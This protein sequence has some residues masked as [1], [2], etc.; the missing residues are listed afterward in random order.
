MTA[1]SNVSYAWQARRPL[2]RMVDVIALTIV[3]GIAAGFAHSAELA[4]AR[5]IQG[6][7]VWFSRDF[8]WMSPIA[9]TLVLLPG[10]VLLALLALASGSRWILGL[11]VLSTASAAVFGALLPYSQ[12]ARVVSL[13]LALVVGVQLARLTISSPH[14]TMRW[15]RRVAAGSVVVVGALALLTPTFRGWRESR[16]IAEAPSAAADVPNILVIIL[17][18]VRAASFGLYRSAPATTPRLNE[19]ARESVVFD[20]AYAPAPWTLPSHAS[21]F[22]G[23]YA[24]ELDANWKI[25]L[26]DADSTL[27]EVFRQR[28]YATGAFVGNMH[29]TAWDSGL[30][31]GFAAYRD[32]RTTWNQL[33]LS[34]SYTQTRLIRQLRAAR[35]FSAAVR[36]VRNSDLSIDMKHTFDHKRG[37]EVSRSFLNWQQSIGDRPFLAF[38]NYFD[39]HQP[40]YAPQA[41]RTFPTSTTSAIHMYHAAIAWLDAQVDGVLDT[42]RSRGAL[43]RTVVIVTSDH[44]ELF[45]EHGLSGHAHNLYRNVLWIP[46]LVRFPSRVPGNVRVDATVSLRDLA[47]TIADLAGVATPPFPGTSLAV[48]W[49]AGGHRTSPLIG[50]VRRAPNVG[51]GYPTARGDLTSLTDSAWHFIRN[52]DGREELFAWRV[53]PARDLASG[54]GS[55]ADVAPLRARL[56][57]LLKARNTG[58][59]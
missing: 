33:L 51:M 40:Y 28:G 48:T 50:E 44:G 17:D 38:L 37:H 7:L 8:L 58:S 11:A 46:L 27:A 43:D 22:T 41:F 59:R 39:A 13:F 21:F 15:A 16:A 19:W 6:Q 36:A 14:K 9:Y 52:S 3:F 4:F 32:Y 29:Y 12:I 45:N 2:M 49:S 24:G 47:A 5:H 55:Q 53:D 31:R 35:S 10:G 56:D 30:D 1:K 42:L 57:S 25:P 34:S 18:T 23:R 26:G 54:N 20:N